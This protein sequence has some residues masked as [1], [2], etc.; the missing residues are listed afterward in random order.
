MHPRRSRSQGPR[1]CD[2]ARLARK[3]A[4]FTPELQDY[5]PFK[6]ELTLQNGV[7]FKVPMKQKTTAANLKGS[8]KQRRTAPSPPEHLPS[9]QR[10]SRFCTLS[11]DIIG[12]STKTVQHP[13][14]NISRNTK[15]VFFKPGTR[16]V[17]HKRNKM[18]PVVPSP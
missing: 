3:Q 8:S 4:S 17:H 6:E 11:D 9:F 15:A 2:Q 18:T 7:I 5:F 14:K 1:Q 12:G 10:Y 13:I 16:N